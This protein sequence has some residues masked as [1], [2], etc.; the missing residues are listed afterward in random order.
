MKI[1]FSHK[2][3][4][5]TS[6]NAIDNLVRVAILLDVLVINLE[7]LSST[8][9]E[10]DTDCRLFPLPKKGKYMM[11]LF[12]KAGYFDLFPTLRRWTPDKYDYYK[13]GI[14]KLFDIEYV[15]V[16]K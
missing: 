15:E 10:Y 6:H 3:R 8:F 11:L 7:E 14:G 13:S 12:Q 1:K 5:L 9:L 4:K 16:S 2:Y